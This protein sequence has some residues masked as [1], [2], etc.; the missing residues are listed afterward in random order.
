MNMLDVFYSSEL[1]PPKA[2]PEID[3]LNP[4]MAGTLRIL[5][6]T[7][8]KAA[9]RYVPA[10]DISL[11]RIAIQNGEEKIPC[12]LVEPAQ[13]EGLLPG[14]LMLHGGAFYVPIEVKTLEMA[15]FYARELRARVVVPEYRLVPS[16]TAPC[17]L[18]DCL[19]VFDEI[20]AHGATFR[21][22]PSKILLVGDSA[23]AALAAGICLWLR[24]EKRTL[25]KGQLLIYP[26]LDDRLERYA[27][28]EQY[29]EAPLSTAAVRYMWR[30]YLKGAEER[31]VPFLIPAR[32][33]DLTGLPS[34]YIEPAAF[35]CAKDEALV[36]GERLQNAG[37]QVKIHVV[38]EAYHG[39]DQDLS[40]PLVQR[41]VANRVQ[42]M[43]KMLSM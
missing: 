8:K 22:D 32:E 43:E 24:N 29:R 18:E 6:L 12:Y 37:N 26:V 33:E 19:A 10:K 1:N 15:S 25:P 39:F 38:E 34:T 2:L 20:T 13:E 31:M 14:V 30:A 5:S 21:M 4:A 23:G 28:Y 35:D 16:H 40:S 27:S 9:E 11:S 42:V 17:Q 7:L 36:F 3:P 41:V